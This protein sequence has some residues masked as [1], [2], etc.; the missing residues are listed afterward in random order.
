MAEL[1]E[2]EIK[3]NIDTELEKYCDSLREKW[4]WGYCKMCPL[5]SNGLCLK[6]IIKYNAWD[7]LKTWRA[8]R[9]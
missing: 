2:H 9:L 5:S 7:T 4:S 3:F 6:R 1:K 8:G